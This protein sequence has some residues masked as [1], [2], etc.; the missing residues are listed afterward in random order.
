MM[1]RGF[2]KQGQQKHAFY[3]GWLSSFALKA[4][5]V[6]PRISVAQGRKACFLYRAGLH[7]LAS[8][9]GNVAVTHLCFHAARALG[10]MLP[11]LGHGVSIAGPATARAVGA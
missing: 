7:V 9:C 1:P 2:H 4:G 6:A 11:H 5:N 10:W 3:F 8:A